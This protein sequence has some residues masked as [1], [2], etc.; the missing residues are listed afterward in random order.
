MRT[1]RWIP[2]DPHCTARG[3]RVEDLQ[4]KLRVNN[5]FE[6][7][8]AGRKGVGL[9]LLLCALVAIGPSPSAEAHDV[10]STYVQ[11]GVHL[12]IGAHHVDLTLDLT[13]FEEWSTRERRSM[14]A[15]GKGNISQAEL[16]SYVQ[17]LAPQLAKSLKL[18]VAG[19]DLPLVPLYDPEVD[20]R[21]SQKV[22]QAQHRL[23]LFLFAPTP[24]L[25]EGDEIVIEDHLWPEAKAL[26]T[27]H[28]EGRDGCRLTAET[29]V[30]ARFGKA[31]PD[32]GHLFKFRCLKPPGEPSAAQKAPLG[33]SPARS[34]KFSDFG[35][36]PKQSKT[37]SI[38]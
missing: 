26:S 2:L 34:S 19:R 9:V 32:A 11:H 30:D 6:P 27:S 22:G 5:S 31:R 17:K 29:S 37:R 23:R 28:A 21:G 33:G 7:L 8:P 13:F 1:S 35:P 36:V 25:H 18:R 24:M 10:F 12:A 3:K 14:D 38:L 16:E 20:L 15:D 4:R